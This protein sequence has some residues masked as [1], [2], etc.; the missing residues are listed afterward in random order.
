MRRNKRAVKF[1]TA[2]CVTFS[3]IIFLKF[4]DNRCSVRNSI[5]NDSRKNRSV[6]LP[7]LE[8]SEMNGNSATANTKPIGQGGRL[9]RSTVGVMTFAPALALKL[10]TAVSSFGLGAVATSTVL[11]GEALA[12]CSFSLADNSKYECTGT[13]SISSTFTHTGTFNSGMQIIMASGVTFSFTSGDAFDLRNDANGAGITFTQAANGND[14]IGNVRGMWIRNWN[15]GDIN[16]T[17]TGKVEGQNNDGLI[18]RN[19]GSGNVNINVTDVKAKFNAMYIVQRAQDQTLTITST[20]IIENTSNTRRGLTAL[21]RQGASIVINANNISSAGDATRINRLN[22]NGTFSVSFSGTV[23]AGS[24]KY[25]EGVN[26][27]HD[28]GGTGNTLTVNNIS[29]GGH[30]IY[31][32]LTNA[33]DVTVTATGTISSTR[34]HGIFVYRKENALSTTLT[35]SAVTGF[36]AGIFHSEAQGDRSNRGDVSI[37]ASDHVQ[38]TDLESGDGI[39]VQK[40]GSGSV[41]IRTKDVTGGREGI[42]VRKYDAGSVD[43]SV[44]GDI[45]GLC[46][47]TTATADCRVWDDT[48]IY[49]YTDED[50]TNLD[51]AVTTAGSVSG[52][53]GIH[54]HHVGDGVVTINT[55]GDVDGNGGRGIY[56]YSLGGDDIDN[57]PGVKVTVDNVDASKEGIYVKTDSKGEGGISITVNESGTVYGEDAIYAY[58]EDKGDI[59]ISIGVNATAS[60]DVSFGVGAANKSRGGDITITS[61]AGSVISSYTRPGTGLAR[62]DDAIYVFQGAGGGT[63]SVNLSGNVKA[64]QDGIKV[65]NDSNSTTTITSN[66]EISGATGGGHGIYVNNTGNGNVNITISGNVTG[67]GTIDSVTLPPSTRTNRDYSFITRKVIRGGREIIEFISWASPSVT[68]VPGTVLPARV[69]YALNLNS[70]TSGSKASGT[71]TVTVTINSG[72]ISASTG[73]QANSGGGAILNGAG[74]STITFN[75]GTTLNGKVSLGGGVDTLVFSGATITANTVLDGGAN[76]SSSQRDSVRFKD[77]ASTSDGAITLSS[78]NILNFER[79]Y[80]DAGITW[81]FNGSATI[82]AGTTIASVGTLSMQDTG[83]PAADDSLTIAGGLINQGG[84]NATKG[85]V[86]VDVDFINATSDMLILSASATFENTFV[87]IRD[88]SANNTSPRTENEITVIRLGAEDDDGFSLA[89]GATTLNSGGTD[90]TFEYRSAGGGLPA[91]W[92]LSAAGLTLEDCTQQ[93]QTGIFTCTG[94]IDVSEN[95]SGTGSIDV[96]ATLDDSATVNVAQGIA[97]RLTGNSGVRFVQETGG[98]TI[99][100]TSNS[101]RGVVHILSG[102]PGS[103]ST[104]NV[105]ISLVGSALLEGNGKAI[106]AKSQTVGN[107]TVSVANVTA[108]H[109][110]A[111]AIEAEANGQSLTIRAATVSAGKIGIKASTA[112]NTGTVS[113][114]TTGLITVGASGFGVDATTKTG[115]L[116]ISTSGITAGVSGRGIKATALG[117]GNISITNSGDISINVGIGIDT[118]TAGGST[119]IT[120]NDGDIESTNS[121]DSVSIAIRN[122]EGNS[123]IVVNSGASIGANVY[124]G[125]GTDVLTFNGGTVDTT[126]VDLT[127]DGGDDIIGT[128]WTDV[129]N[130]SGNTTTTALNPS[131]VRNWEQINVSTNAT[132]KFNGQHSLTTGQLNLIGTLSMQDEAPSDALTLSGNLIGSGKI[133]IDVNFSTGTADVLNVGGNV[134]GTHTIVVEDETPSDQTTRTANPI[135]LVVVTGRVAANSFTLGDVSTIDSGNSLYSLKYNEST[136]TFFLEGISRPLRCVEGNTAGEFTCAGRISATENILKTTSVAF[137]VTLDDAAIVNVSAGVAFHVHGTQAVTFTQEVGGNVISA[138]GTATGVV[139]AITTGSGDVSVTLTGTANL[140]GAGVAV[141]ASTTDTG[142]VTVSTAKVLAANDDAIAVKAVASGGNI[143]VTTADVSGG[144]YGVYAKNRGATGSISIAAN[145]IGSGDGYGIYARNDGAGGVTISAASINSK[146]DGID[147]RNYLSGDLLISARGSITTSTSGSVDGISALDEGTG[148]VTVNAA[149][150]VTGADDGIDVVNEGGGSIVISATGTIS[151]AGTGVGD[152]GIF[153]QNDSKGLDITISAGNASTVSGEYG[154][155]VYNE[156]TGAVTV[157]NS[158]TL[159][160]NGDQ[161][162]YIYQAG[163]T[164][165]A[166]VRRVEGDDDGVRIKHYGSETA[167]LT[168]LQGGS[169]SAEKKGIH[170][171]SSGSGDIV[172]AVSGAVTGTSEQGIYAYQSG[173]GKIAINI[174]AVGGNQEGIEARNF[175]SGGITIVAAGGITAGSSHDGLL[176]YDDSSGGVSVT[177]SSVTGGDDGVQIINKSGGDVTANLNGQVNSTSSGSSDA[178]LYIYN[179]ETDGD[180]TVNIA[181]AG[182][183]RGMIGVSITNESDGGITISSSGGIASS[184]SGTTGLEVYSKGGDI[185]ITL[186]NRVYGKTL[187]ID[188]KNSG[189]GATNLLINSGRIS[190]SGGSAIAQTGGSSSITVGN[191]AIIEG[192]VSLGDGVD[193]LTFSGANAFDTTTARYTF[194]GGSDTGTDASKDIVNFVGLSGTLNLSKFNNF[195]VL[196]LGTGTTVTM[197]S[198]TTLNFEEIRLSGGTIDVSDNAAD[199]VLTISGNLTSGGGFVIDTN[200]ASGGTDSITISGNVTGQHVLTINDIAPSNAAS[201]TDNI[202]VVTVTGTASSGAVVL[203]NTPRFGAKIFRLTYDTASKTF[204]LKAADGNLLCAES[205]TVTGTFVC[206]GTIGNSENMIVDPGTNIIATLAS[207]ATV[208]VSAFVAFNLEGEGGISFVQGASGNAITGTASSLGLIHAFSK[209]SGDHN[210]VITINGDA[211]FAGEGTAISATAQGTGDI[212]ITTGKVTASNASGKTIV[213]TGKGDSVTVVTNDVIVGGNG[214]ITAKNTSESGRVSVTASSTVTSTTGT[215]IDAYGM[216]ASVTVS[217]SAA[218]TG[219]TGIKAVNKSSGAGTVAVHASAAVTANVG[220]GIYAYNKG[221]G[222]ITITAESTIAAK[223]FGIHAINHTSGNISITVSSSITGEAGSGKDG[224]GATDKGTGNITVVAG[225]VT[226]DDDGI[227]ADNAGGGSVSVTVSGDILGRDGFDAGSREGAGI[228]LE[229]DASGTDSTLTVQGAAE[230]KGGYGVYVKHKASGA[231]SIASTDEVIGTV[232]DGVYVLNEGTTTNISINTVLGEKRGINLKHKGSGNVTIASSG[233]ITGTTSGGIEVEQTA[234]SDVS[235]AVA[236]VTGG[237]DGIWV[238]TS[239]SGNVT[240]TATGAV[241]GSDSKGDGIYVH[242]SGVGNVSITAIGVKGSDRGIDARNYGG[243]SISVT[244]NGAVGATATGA[245]DAGISTYD[246]ANGGTI[247]VNLGVGGTSSGNFGIYS[248]SKGSGNL[249]I[250]ASGAVTGIGRSGI[251]VNKLNSGHIVV[252]VDDVTGSGHGVAITNIGFGTTNLTVSGDV[253]AGGDTA[254]HGIMFAGSTN[255]GN[256]SI[257]LKSGSTVTGKVAG[258]DVT[259]SSAGDITITSNAVV[260]GGTDGIRV[261]SEGTGDISL[262]VSGNVVAGTEGVGI[263]TKVSTGTASIILNAGTIG[264]KTS[265]KNNNGASTIRVNGATVINGDIMLGGGIDDLT[266][267]G[268][269]FN[270]SATIDG[271]EDVGADSSVDV[272]RFNSGTVSASAAN[273]VNWESIV[274]S[275]GVTL[276]FGG[277]TQTLV[278]SE[279]ALAGTLSL[280]DTAANDALTLSGNLVGAAGDSANRTIAIDV[281]LSTGDTDTLTI[282]GNLS[283][284]NV[285]SIVDVSP[286]NERTRVT[287]PITVVTV[288]GTTSSSSL[289][290]TGGRLVSRGYIYELT[291]DSTAKTF[292]LNGKRGTLLCASS[293]TVVGQFTCGGTLTTPENITASGSESVSATLAASATVRVTDDIAFRLSSQS[294]TTF[295]QSSG[296]AAINAVDRAYGV[297]LATSSGNGNVSVTLTGT[298]SLEGSG[299][300]IEASS[301][302]TGD[303]TV[304]AT[305]VQAN[306]ANGTGI[307]VEGRGNISVRAAVVSGGSAGVIARNVGTTTGAVSV[308]VTGAITSSGT[309]INAYNRSGNVTVNAGGAITATAIGVMATNSGGPGNVSVVTNGAVTSS[310]SGIQAHNMGSGTVS[311]NAAS[312]ISASGTMGIDVMAGENAGNVTINAGAVSGQQTA[313]RVQHARDGAIAV[314]TTGA[315]S[316]QQSSAISVNAVGTS[317]VTVVV[318]GTVTG[319]SQ[320]AAIYAASHG[321]ATS[322]TL[323]SGVTVSAVSG[324]AIRNDH[325]NSAV[326]VNS[327]ATVSGSVF[328]GGGVDT[329]TFATGSFGDSTLDGGIDQ[330]ETDTS[331]DVLTVNGGSFAILDGK[332]LNWESIVLGNQAIATVDGNRTLTVD[333]LTVQGSISMQDRVAN[334]SLTLTSNLTGGGTLV[335]DV[336]FFIGTSDRLVVNGN[337]TGSTTID[338]KDISIRAGG[339]EDASITIVTVSGEASANAF[340]LINNGFTAGEYQYTL[341]FNSSDKTYSLSRKESVGSVMLVAAP[342][343]LFDGFARLPSMQE[344]RSSGDFGQRGWSRLISSKNTYGD[345]PVGRAE[346]ETQNTGLQVGF[347]LAEQVGPSGTWVYGVTAQYNKVDGDVKAVT[348]AGTLTAEGYGIGGTATWYGAAGA[349]VDVQAQYNMISTDFVVGDNV[350]ALINGEDSTAIVVGVEIGKRHEINDK[351]SILSS[352]QMSWGRVDVSDFVTANSQPVKFGG[353][354]DGISARFG[355]QVDY[356]YNTEYQGYVLANVHYDTYD[357]WDITFVNSK[358]EDSVAPVMGEFGLGGSFEVSPEATIYLQAAV[359]K[360]FGEEFEER[361]STSLTAG[362][363]WS[364]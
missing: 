6:S 45:V 248:Y 254:G 277:G 233:S 228:T 105:E 241:A 90:F 120:L 42:F 213:A 132:V 113:I 103:T 4:I 219:G 55:S 202:T 178:G 57:E 353:D 296:G 184:S 109:A 295:V 337:V 163:T 125:M 142:N 355:V 161:G 238:K 91:R 82:A 46:G 138:T 94:A 298:A 34:R 293:T 2:R 220:D 143:V 297:V 268:T 85:T 327:G 25:H 311:V 360:S 51:I 181:S 63:V 349:Y 76:P 264:G 61:S 344:R 288:T 102:S 244:A 358:Y 212:T 317:A 160:G 232:T 335:V 99:S 300:A 1:S 334:D 195:E 257:D 12:T 270:S 47:A 128:T 157:Y 172:L 110:S 340:N 49:A 3:S 176:A 194:D 116:T 28:G 299:T 346:Y 60:S 294:S 58:N 336:D 338:V 227:D 251:H 263:D 126:N 205:S 114:S 203:R 332:L 280:Q 357:S 341:T 362:V 8:L 218:V 193:K 188:L 108:S 306:H 201:Y 130:F 70:V 136:K 148:G 40:T 38:A 199:D 246:D 278:V 139:R 24:S 221:Q 321:S 316:S 64:A 93:G 209:G 187:A 153:A 111:T 315:V 150:A 279:V 310:G 286:A 162:V 84:P 170:A 74:N 44:S 339:N 56:V 159:I 133:L 255:A 240:V 53:Y 260:T 359:K 173:D 223:V 147:A 180:I 226:G 62:G 271:G 313:V 356:A 22:R 208:N 237:N 192:D 191:N 283:G 235:I 135:N 243:G 68:Q 122:D 305:T 59:N 71:G 100:A 242:Q 124:L 320:G 262:T 312:P 101:S 36:S 168:V 144:S 9:R 261:T 30:G 140:A 266:F 95:M 236:A 259:S 303:V 239:Y 39:F 206:S 231:V 351:I 350:G 149:G 182:S 117:T 141:E 92:V 230:V 253:V 119:T 275:S 272:L 48:G 211:T 171:T 348:T 107:V 363:R 185:D 322:I 54:A 256:V 267:A 11:A 86:A 247:L 308:N 32:N 23:R 26:I 258:I 245:K 19:Y 273:L 328:L 146:K 291:F 88:I 307:K 14:I 167:T 325:H 83:T 118:F 79:I 345:A 177:L 249:T 333:N 284:S 276:S 127:L 27:L 361:D 158:G 164:V 137:D 89:G 323:N 69:G 204:K 319:G 152:A 217:A 72:T 287:T 292:T 314:T 329:L 250:N 77:R 224:I 214:G 364:W 52:S 21:A 15:G 81:K 326:T 198:S 13:A 215:A 151:A 285:L 301:T 200:I 190:S 154:I 156:G 10:L 281:N 290:L 50:T 97:F 155:Y 37:T 222:D 229:N 289:S 29:A 186:N 145:S 98:G 234:S 16:V 5:S 207:D 75:S 65:R 43:I 166:T 225:A 66:G 196:E 352:G 216:G 115:N 87:S 331:V 265:I 169:I 330:G 106:Y 309:G 274:I 175:G 174:Q 129:L 78:A 304:V 354:D 183:V 347:E 189:T 318:N 96:V 121:S 41:T 179:D 20:G 33:K 197:S 123:T 269:S 31:L 342:I 73:F 165:S 210:V 35:V 7:N 282:R 252:N 18:V 67:G 302:G 17:V 134:T 104:G 112:A 131:K 343:A 324:V 80:L